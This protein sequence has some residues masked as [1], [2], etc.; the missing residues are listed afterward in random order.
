MRLRRANAWSWQLD[1]HLVDPLEVVPPK[2]METATPLSRRVGGAGVARSPAN[3][4][5]GGDGLARSL[6]VV[7]TSVGGRCCPRALS[8]AR[9]LAARLR[10]AALSCWRTPG[11][12]VQPEPFLHPPR[13]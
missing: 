2:R 1:V 13:Q 10:H 7:S 11:R 4:T 6:V 3:A 12:F 8:C 5:A 9:G